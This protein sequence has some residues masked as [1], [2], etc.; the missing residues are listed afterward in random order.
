MSIYSN[1]SILKPEF[2]VALGD[3]FYTNG[4]Q[5]ST[6]SLWDSLWKEV[7]LGIYILN[8]ILN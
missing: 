1:Q 8:F 3:N 7:Y 2:I 5:S 4:V 6:D